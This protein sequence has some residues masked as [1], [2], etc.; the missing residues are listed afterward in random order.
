MATAARHKSARN[1]ANK[2]INY[3]TSKKSK[4]AMKAGDDDLRKAA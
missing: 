4:L 3:I 1:K 2:A